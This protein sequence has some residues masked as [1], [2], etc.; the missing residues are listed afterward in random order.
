MKY[1]GFLIDMDGVIFRNSMEIGVRLIHSYLSA[2]TPI[3][4][5]TVLSFVRFGNSH[6]PKEFYTHIFTA[7]GI[8]DSLG[9]FFQRL[10]TFN[11]CRGA[12]LE[13]D[14][15]F[16]PFVEMCLYT[17]IEYR[18]FSLA[19]VQR[20]TAS[21]PFVGPDKII[22]VDGAKSNVA[23]FHRLEEILPNRLNEWCLIDDD[24]FALRSA[25]L[26]GLGTCMM[27]NSVFGEQQYGEYAGFIDMKVGGF[28][29][30]LQ[31]VC[32]NAASGRQGTK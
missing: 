9:D 3:A 30:L 11:G 32:Q 6:P 19:P 10:A 15:Q 7:L 12:M 29:E 20:I 28:G 26:A 1:Q 17:G 5:Q 13:M 22:A 8:A 31:L 23:T 21:V 16:K 18:I 24:P 27:Q 4:Y 25:K 14:K 2:R